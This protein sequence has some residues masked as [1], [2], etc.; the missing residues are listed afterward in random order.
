MRITEEKRGCGCR[1]TGTVL[2]REAKSGNR[3]EQGSDPE[4]PD[5]ATDQILACDSKPKAVS[6]MRVPQKVQE[7]KGTGGRIR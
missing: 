4:R 3:G 2:F 1:E 7:G 6:V 5:H